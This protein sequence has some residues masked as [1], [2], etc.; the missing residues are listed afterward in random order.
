MSEVVR[1]ANDV[2]HPISGRMCNHVLWLRCQCDESCQYKQGLPSLDGCSIGFETR[3][4]G[5][6]GTCQSVVRGICNGYGSLAKMSPNLTFSRGDFCRTL[7]RSHW[8]IEDY[9][10]RLSM[11]S[12]RGR[13][14]SFSPE[15]Y[16][17]G[18]CSDYWWSWMWPLEYHRSNL[19]I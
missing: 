3:L 15:L 12:F 9:P 6:R 14:P 10:T 2:R 7:R 1:Q 11:G 17:D 16:L 5:N 13:T 18:I 19:D 8:T 4:G